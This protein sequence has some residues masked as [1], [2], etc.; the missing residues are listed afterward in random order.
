MN[1]TKKIKEKEQKRRQVIKVRQS[2][3]QK[4]NKYHKKHERKNKSAGKRRP[5]VKA[6]YEQQKYCWQQSQR[7]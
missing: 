1:T 2:G 3:N 6:V 5:L 4:S 7:R